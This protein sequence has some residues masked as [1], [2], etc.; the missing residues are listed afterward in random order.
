ME[1]RSVLIRVGILSYFVKR[2]KPSETQKINETFCLRD[3][4]ERMMFS[5]TWKIS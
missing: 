5:A 4:M 3:Y 2:L 1:G